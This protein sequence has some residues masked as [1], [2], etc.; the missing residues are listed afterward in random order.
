MTI[1]SS[2]I[3]GKLCIDLDAIVSNWSQ[4]AAHSSIARCA[5]VVKADAYGLGAAAVT[6]ALSLA[7]CTDFFVASAQE[8]YDLSLLL[9][10][11]ANIFVLNGY[12]VAEQP[13]F[14]EAGLTPVLNSEHQIDSW[15]RS[16]KDAPCALMVDTGIN[17]LGIAPQQVNSLLA[18]KSSALNLTW[19]LSHFACADEPEHPLNRQQLD[20]FNAVL[21]D[22][23]LRYPHVQASMASTAAIFLGRGSDFDLLR[24]GIGLYGGS[25]DPTRPQ[26]MAPVVTLDLPV[27]QIKRLAETATVGY[28]A[29]AT[30]PA[31]RVLA[32][33]F[34]GYADGLMRSLANK[35]QGFCL[36]EPV[37]L[38]GRVSMDYCVF[39]IS[40]AIAKG[41]RPEACTSIE[42]LG[43]NQTVD[44]LAHSAGTLAYE[45]LTSL[46][47][48]YDRH[49]LSRG[50]SG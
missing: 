24:P 47:S 2:P 15:R 26:S 42:L 5:A 35:A 20:R 6:R 18:N 43:P 25:P 7:G 1:Y 46:G 33:V 34:G 36:G 37:P 40:G 22:V 13:L 27:L 14:A 11:S 30:L 4:L 48:R 23:R 41:I 32:T 3:A 31:G 28:G 10:S 8:G 16:T 45:I 12:D 19:L 38:I 29:T 21:R 49:Y 39:D 17:R 50:F 9:D 44:S